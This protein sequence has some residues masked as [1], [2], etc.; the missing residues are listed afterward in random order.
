ML[1]WQETDRLVIEIAGWS[2]MVVEAD[3]VGSCTLVAFTVTAVP[4]I[5]AVRLPFGAIAP[6]DADQLTAGEKAPVPCTGAV[7]AVLPPC[8]M[9]WAWQA[10]DTLVIVTG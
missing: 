6:A 5:G 9:L 1:S 2:A 8:M 3:L 7:Q 4:V 10:T